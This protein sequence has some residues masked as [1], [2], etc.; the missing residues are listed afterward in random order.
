[1]ETRL[2]WKSLCNLSG[3]TEAI[4][5]ENAHHKRGCGAEL[6]FETPLIGENLLLAHGPVAFEPTVSAEQRFVLRCVV[7][8][9]FIVRLVKVVNTLRFRGDGS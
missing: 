9:L 3:G 4:C 6:S 8:L 5:T 7:F 2:T 1:M